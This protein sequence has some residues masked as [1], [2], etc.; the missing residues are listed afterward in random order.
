MNQCFA[1]RNIKRFYYLGDSQVR[2][3]YYELPFM[4]SDSEEMKKK[5]GDDYIAKLRAAINTNEKT[6][7]EVSLGGGITIRYDSDWGLTWPDTERITAKN[8]MFD[9]ADGV[10]VFIYN[11]G[12]HHAS[13]DEVGLRAWMK[14]KASDETLR[15]PPYLLHPSGV[16]IQGARNPRMTRTGAQSSSEKHN[17]LF[18]NNGF[19][20]IDV[21]K[22]T[23]FRGPEMTF[24]N[25]DGFHYSTNVMKMGNMAMLNMICN[26][27]KKG[28]EWYSEGAKLEI[29]SFVYNEYSFDTK[30]DQKYLYAHQNELRDFEHGGWKKKGD[31]DLA[32]INAKGKI[33]PQMLFMRSDNND[34]FT[35]YNVLPPEQDYWKWYSS[36]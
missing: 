7:D 1:Q 10:D 27:E 22:S 28:E 2:A 17:V 20:A 21:M 32:E 23:T 36:V 33:A 8:K 26:T 24:L 25:H 30:V 19:V 16:D 14:S 35:S 4:I 5:L 15:V 18:K 34:H 12:Q 13:L 31:V 29:T 6:G 9:K 11:A 3:L